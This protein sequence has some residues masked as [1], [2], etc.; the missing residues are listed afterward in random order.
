MKMTFGLGLISVLLTSIVL[1]TIGIFISSHNNNSKKEENNTFKYVFWI[2]IAVTCII[3]SMFALRAGYTIPLYPQNFIVVALFIASIITSIISVIKFNKEDKRVAFRYFIVFIA[4]LLGYIAIVLFAKNI[5][6]IIP[7]I[8]L[9]VI[10]LIE[11]FLGSFVYYD[12]KKRGMDPWMW[13]V[14]AV[15]IPNLM[16]LIIYFVSRGNYEKKCFNCGKSVNNEYKVC[17]YCGSALN[18]SCPNCGRNISPDWMVCPYC[19]QKLRG[20]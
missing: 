14:V 9:N 20:I 17:P 15:F 2:I 10:I 3:C 18:K 7:L 19:S 1:I 16:G 8:W 13:T 12:A 4:A 11:S 6:G 5:Y